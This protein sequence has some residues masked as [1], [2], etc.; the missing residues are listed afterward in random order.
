MDP[1]GFVLE[2][3]DMVGTW[4]ELDGK[5]A[6]NTAGELV[7]GTKV[8]GVADL[9]NA[10]LSRREMFVTNATQKLLSYATGRTVHYYDMPAVRAIVRN[11]SANDYRFS[12]LALGIIQSDAFQKKIKVKK[13]AE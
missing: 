2:N 3:F 9:R 5:T 1:L 11:A 8:N 13:S 7:D 10:I 6:I 12:S 4:R